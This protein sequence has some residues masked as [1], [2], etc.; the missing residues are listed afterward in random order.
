[1]A[2]A[3]SI[4]RNLLSFFETTL[5]IWKMKGGTRGTRGRA[6]ADCASRGGE[7]GGDADADVVRASAR[8]HDTV[9]DR[10]L[11][12]V[13]LLRDARHPGVLHGRAI[14]TA[15]AARVSGIRLIHSVR[16]LHAY[17]GWSDFRQV[18]GTRSGCVDRRLHH[19]RRTFHDGV[20]AAVLCRTRHHRHG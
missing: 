9:P 4:R 14:G 19:G 6:E 17:P 1:M 11:G 3:T 13:L 2:G 20:R 12:A 5:Y 8:T 7:V 16:L 18:V 15:P 10:H